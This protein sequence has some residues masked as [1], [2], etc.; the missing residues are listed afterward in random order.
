MFSHLN[1]QWHAPVS[2]CVSGLHRRVEEVSPCQLPCLPSYLDPCSNFVAKVRRLTVDFADS[3]PKSR[4]EHVVPFNLT[5][6]MNWDT[7]F[8][9]AFPF[10]GAC[11]LHKGRQPKSTWW[12]FHV[13][14]HFLPIYL[15]ALFQ[16]RRLKQLCSRDSQMKC[17][18][19][20]VVFEARHLR[21][22]LAANVQCLR[23]KW[24]Q[25]FYFCVFNWLILSVWRQVLFH[26]WVL[27]SP[28]TRSPFHR[29]ALNS[30]CI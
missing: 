25:I 27:L 7:I 2:P 6:E 29:L 28:E 26:I 17:K 11:I 18:H 8:E 4:I 3:Y 21:W 10:S 14:F 30:P 5:H 9:M 24:T 19:V 23:G 1:S 13:A 22:Q 16:Y 15:V 12:I 20:P